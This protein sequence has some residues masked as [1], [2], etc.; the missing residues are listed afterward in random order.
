MPSALVQAAEVGR[1]TCTPEMPEEVAPGVYYV[2]YSCSGPL[3]VHVLEFDLADPQYTMEMGFAQGQRNYGTA[4]EPVSQI[5]ARHDGAGHNVL[6]AVNCG[7]FSYDSIW[8]VGILGSGSNY[9]GPPTPGSNLETYMLQESGEGWGRPQYSRALD[10]GP[11]CRRSRD[12]RRH[13]RQLLRQRDA[14]SVH[15]GLGTQHRLHD[16]GR[17]GDCRGR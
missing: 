6:G 12:G 13:L 1:L 7:F 16:G 3:V 5:A 4:R 15:T 9:I 14:R 11:F 8:L 2:A 10:H 17:R